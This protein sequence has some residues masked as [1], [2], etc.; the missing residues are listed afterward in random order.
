MILGELP[1][2]DAKNNRLVSDIVY[3]LVVGSARQH[4]CGRDSKKQKITVIYIPPLAS[5]TV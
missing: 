2:V 3:T 1:I 4:C 5:V